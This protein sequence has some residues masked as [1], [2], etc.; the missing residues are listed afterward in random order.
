MHTDSDPRITDQESYMVGLAFRWA[1]WSTKDP[2]WDHDHCEFCWAKFPATPGE[3][4]GHD[5][6]WLTTDGDLWVCA[7]CFTDF[8]ERFEWTVVA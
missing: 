8:T 7:Q 3:V 6:G 2:R 1:Q 4:N 5:E